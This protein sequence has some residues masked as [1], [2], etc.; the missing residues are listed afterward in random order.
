MKMK[1]K[2]NLIITTYYDIRTNMIKKNITYN[3]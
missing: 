1:K 3:I 2:N